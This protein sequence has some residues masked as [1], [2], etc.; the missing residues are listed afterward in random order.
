MWKEFFLDAATDLTE[1]EIFQN[2]PVSAL[3]KLV[4]NLKH[5]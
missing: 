3:L 4:R 5:L 2:E 1:R